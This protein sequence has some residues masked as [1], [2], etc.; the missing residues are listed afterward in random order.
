MLIGPKI[1]ISYDA[2]KEEAQELEDKRAA[3]KALDEALRK[4]GEP[5]NW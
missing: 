5:G 2:E 3:L 4:E 1:Q